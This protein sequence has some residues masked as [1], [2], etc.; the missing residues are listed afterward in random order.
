VFYVFGGPFK[1]LNF[2]VYNNWGELVFE[3]NK[4]SYGWDGTF[5]GV[6]QPMGPYVYTVVA[7][8]EDDKEYKT[9]GD[10]TLLR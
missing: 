2:R 1:T 7:V 4:Q 8:T 9:S 5:K 10:V 6:D 3:S